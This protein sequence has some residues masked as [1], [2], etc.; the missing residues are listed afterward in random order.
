MNRLHLHLLLALLA[1]ALPAAADD[2]NRLPAPQP[3]LADYFMR[4]VGGK[5][6]R[7]VESHEVKANGCID[8]RDYWDG[9]AG[10]GP[11]Q[12]AFT[13][14]SVTT[15]MDI[16]AYPLK[17]YRRQAFAF[18]G[19]EG[20]VTAGGAEVFRVI[21]VTPETLKILKYQA[22]RG[23]G[24]PVYVYATYRAMSA[25][26]LDSC[27][28]SHRYDLDTFNALYPVVP[29]QERL[30]AADFESRAVGYGWRCTEMHK[31]ETDWRYD[32]EDC[33]GGFEA[34]AA[35]DYFISADS[36][37]ACLPPAPGRQGSSASVK[38]TYL[39]NGFY[40]STG[41][42]TGF[43]VLSVGDSE[44]RIL[45]RLPSADGSQP[46]SL[47]CVYRKMTDDE[48]REFIPGCQMPAPTL[49]K[50]EN[51]ISYVAD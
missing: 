41:V 18:S 47:Y 13:A 48:L 1:W 9:H 25:Q 46:V 17:G 26:E 2:C 50:V 12:Y 16:D 42:S 37:T 11:V 10:G 4:C 19:V 40:V 35:E 34:L 15:F 6:W 44:M 20:R 23:D 27:R 38:Y 33:R 43:R 30:T 28:A 21:S 3:V 31:M 29:E 45:R 5:G 22:M 49:P 39:A 14:D 36:L 51:L 8:K 7:Y 32:A 24:T